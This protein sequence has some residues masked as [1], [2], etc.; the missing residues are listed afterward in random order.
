M[1]LLFVPYLEKNHLI[2]SGLIV[3]LVVFI[4]VENSTAK[5]PNRPSQNEYRKRV[6]KSGMRP[7][8]LPSSLRYDAASCFNAARSAECAPI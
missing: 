3:G 2:A 4:F 6:F 8:A 1:A 5:C 7:S